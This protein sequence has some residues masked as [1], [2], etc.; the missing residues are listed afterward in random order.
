MKWVTRER[1]HVDRVACPWLIKRFIDPDA[2][3]IFVPR[4]T[5]PSTIKEG[6]PFDMKGVKMGHHG[7]K[8]S[9]DAFMEKYDIQD[10]ALK[11]VQSIVSEAD[12]DVVHSPLAVALDVFGRGYRLICKD[13]YETLEKEFYLYDA[14]Y[15]YF[16]K[17]L[18]S[19]AK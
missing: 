17:Q 7:D 2:E 4:D 8:C 16:K 12:S 10:S 5:D 3:F 11:K 18:E 1:V 15:A 19:E 9:F 14:L 6:T 13:D